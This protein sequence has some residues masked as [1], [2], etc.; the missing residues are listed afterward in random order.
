VATAL[1]LSVNIYVIRIMTVLTSLMRSTV[2]TFAQ[3]TTRFLGYPIVGAVVPIPPVYA[4]NFS[5]SVP[6]V[7]VSTQ[8]QI[9]IFTF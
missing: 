9:A 7:V 4:T 5:F 3:R 2:L 1:A 6:M 8:G